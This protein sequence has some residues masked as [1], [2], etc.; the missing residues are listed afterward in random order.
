MKKD[1]YATK[2]FEFKR[3]TKK[4]WQLINEISGKTNNK[5]ELVECLSTNNID[6]CDVK[7]ITNEFGRHFSTVGKKFANSIPKS[8]KSIKDF[9]EKMVLNEKSMYMYHATEIQVDRLIN[10]LENK[11]SSGFNNIS[12]NILKRLKPVILDPTTKII[13][14]SL[15]LG[16]FPSKMKSA[17]VVPLY[18]SKN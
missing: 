17:D 4:F 11:N 14:L 10:K 8:K 13:N 5:T 18:K 15:M 16:G 6:C 1:Y 12:N 7:S 9:I 3:N 2:C